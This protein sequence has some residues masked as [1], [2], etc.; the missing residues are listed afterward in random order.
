MVVRE[1]Q[2][3]AKQRRMDDARALLRTLC[4]MATAERWPLLQAT[5][6]PGRVLPTRLARIAVRAARG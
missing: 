5:G 2:L 4:G 1:L 6:L 3:A